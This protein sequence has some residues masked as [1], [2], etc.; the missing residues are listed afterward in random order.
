MTPGAK[1]TFSL[2]DEIQRPLAPLACSANVGARRAE[3]IP[4]SDANVDTSYTKGEYGMG[5]RRT[6]VDECSCY[7]SSWLGE[8]TEF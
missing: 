5:A 1:L 2:P 4:V 7:T 8:T 3:R 6:L